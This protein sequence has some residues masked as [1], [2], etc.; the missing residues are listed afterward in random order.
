MRV[1]LNR[2]WH[3]REHSDKKRSRQVNRFQRDQEKTGRDAALVTKKES[4]AKNET[5]AL[6]LLPEVTGSREERPYSDSGPR[7]GEACRHDRLRASAPLIAWH[8]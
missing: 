7:Y 4:P 1:L 2:V 3:I 5:P 6:S 8:D